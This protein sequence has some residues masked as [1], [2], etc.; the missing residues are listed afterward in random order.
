MWVW[1]PNILELALGVG[2]RTEVVGDGVAV[3]EA[4][5]L[6]FVCAP[7]SVMH[8]SATATGA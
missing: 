7:D 6:K 3:G 8:A 1:L 5:S 4:F 2:G